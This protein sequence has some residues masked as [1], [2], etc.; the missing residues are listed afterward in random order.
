MARIHLIEGPV[1]AG[2][3]T[4]AAQLSGTYA[5]PHLALDDWMATLFV[6][7]RPDGDIMP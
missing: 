5:A 2:K 6:P 7:D 4:F 1:G 3:S